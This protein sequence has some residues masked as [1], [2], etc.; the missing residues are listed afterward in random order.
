[1]RPAAACANKSTAFI[2]RQADEEHEVRQLVVV[3]LDRV[4]QRAAGRRPAAE[5]RVVEHVDDPQRAVAQPVGVGSAPQAVDRR[6]HEHSRLGG[7]QQVHGA[8]PGAVAGN[9]RRWRFGDR[10]RH[11]ADGRCA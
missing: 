10:R 5:L 7:Q 9:A 2:P 11:D 3:V 1:M 6:Q 4:A 8:H